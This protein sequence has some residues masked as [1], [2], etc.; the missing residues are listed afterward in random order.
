MS[1]ATAMSGDAVTDARTH[2]A[3]PNPP[4]AQRMPRESAASRIGSV[5]ARNR[6]HA[7]ITQETLA[8]YLGVTKA[9]VSKWELGQSAPDIALLPRIAAYFGITCDELLG[10]AEQL[11]E[12]A[13]SRA[14]DE[15][16]DSL[17]SN[18]DRGFEACKQLERAHW[19]DWPL[20]QL[21]AATLLNRSLYRPDRAEDV[22]SYLDA[23]LVRIEDQC[24]DL[25][26]CRAA[27]MMRASLMLMPRTHPR[28]EE[29]VA[30]LES[31]ERDNTSNVATTLA[32]AYDQAGRADD[33]LALRQR[34]VYVAGSSVVNECLNQMEHYRNNP[35]RIAALAHAARTTMDALNLGA[36]MPLV[37]LSLHAQT[38]IAFKNAGMTEQALEEVEL[39]CR[40][41]DAMAANPYA[42]PRL[43]EAVLFDAIFDEING[44]N[45]AERLH[46]MNA[47]ILMSSSIAMVFTKADWS[48]CA[49]DPRYQALLE[50]QSEDFGAAA[51]W[52]ASDHA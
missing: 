18:F 32:A 4:F 51:H 40:L 5:I 14:I 28:V 25:A 12:E 3:Q 11:D 15:L 1:N 42:S 41:I 31:L 34:I 24:D 23:L 26:Q 2:P 10:H 27:R 29:G 45:Q 47:G 21:M 43:H 30:L 46:D 49:D 37:M 35:Q 20:L 19:R 8:Q 44:G 7:G 36:A 48:D 22:F 33:A 39:L 50:R 52:I 38:G 9:A 6:R 16:L 17:K 13:R